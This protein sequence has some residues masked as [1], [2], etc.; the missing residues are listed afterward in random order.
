MNRH[1]EF[2]RALGDPVRLQLVQR[3]ASGKSHTLSSLSDGLDLTRQGVRKHIQVLVDS[4]VI[5]I[6]ASGRDKNVH[7]N[8]ASLEQGRV[9]ILELE[10]RW[11]DRLEALREFVEG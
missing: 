1:S 6:E 2:F 8:R 5:R 3:L 7:L 9:F 10:K 4:D 11:D